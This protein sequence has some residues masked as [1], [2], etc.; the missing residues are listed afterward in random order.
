MLARKQGAQERR[1]Q[2]AQVL[3]L[4]LLNFNGC[5]DGAKRSQR[6]TLLVYRRTRDS[7]RSQDRLVHLLHRPARADRRSFDL[8]SKTLGAKGIGRELRQKDFLVELDAED[9]VAQKEVF[10]D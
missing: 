9:E 7:Q 8:S 6:S 4:A 5:F 1:S 2:S 3:H 10:R